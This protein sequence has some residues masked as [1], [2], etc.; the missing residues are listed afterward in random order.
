M[1][2]KLTSQENKQSLKRTGE[3]AS[4]CYVIAPLSTLSLQRSC[5]SI[6]ISWKNR[7]LAICQLTL[8]DAGH[9]HFHH[10]SVYLS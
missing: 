3:D 7:V 5:L 10:M 9:V 8:Q 1:A 6:K 2:G 4:C